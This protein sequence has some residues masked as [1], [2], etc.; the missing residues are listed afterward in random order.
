MATV[1]S[2]VSHIN[3]TDI[4]ALLCYYMFELHEAPEY[5][6]ISQILMLTGVDEFNRLV[7][8]FN[9]QTVKFPTK[10]EFN[11]KLRTIKLYKAVEIDGKRMKDALIECEYEP[12]EMRIAKNQLAKL[13][14][15]LEKYSIKDVNLK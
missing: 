15:T 7:H 11:D 10:K 6:L 5:A 9:G 4:Y 2:I 8:Y 3:D 1:N 14:A 13:K 12:D